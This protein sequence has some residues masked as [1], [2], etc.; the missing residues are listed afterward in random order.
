MG[1]LRGGWAGGTFSV[2]LVGYV[3]M[4]CSS[5]YIQLSYW[6]RNSFPETS[7]ATEPPQEM[8]AHKRSR[9]HLWLL[10]SVQRIEV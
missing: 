10:P 9:A 4:V 8:S 5:F 2:G 3:H 1:T 6:C 7:A